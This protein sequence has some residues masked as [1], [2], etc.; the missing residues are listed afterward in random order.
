MWPQHL[1]GHLET[2]LLLKLGGLCGAG[3]GGGHHAGQG[4][5]EGTRVGQGTVES[6]MRGRERWGAPC[7]AGNGGGHL[8]GAGNDGGHSGGTGNSGEHVGVPL[9]ALRQVLLLNFRALVKVPEACR[10][11]RT[12]PHVAAVAPST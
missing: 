4:T 12:G 1:T 5:V 8:D 2:L 9:A 10:S 7:W 11:S 3:N 6:T